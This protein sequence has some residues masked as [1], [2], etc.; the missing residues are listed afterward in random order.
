MSNGSSQWRAV[1]GGGSVKTPKERLSLIAEVFLIHEH[2][3]EPSDLPGTAGLMVNRHVWPGRSIATPPP[4]TR[5]DPGEDEQPTGA[6]LPYAS[7]P[8]GEDGLGGELRGGRDDDRTAHQREWDFLA[9]H[10]RA[11]YETYR[12]R[13]VRPWPQAELSDWQKVEALAQYAMQW[14]MRTADVYAGFHPVD[15]LLHSSYCT[16]A[17][18]VLQALA[19]VAG[20]ETRYIAIS[21]HAQVE[22]RVGGR[23]I[24]ADNIWPDGGVTPTP[25]NYAQITEDP[26]AIVLL[27]EKQRELYRVRTARYRAPWHFAGQ[28]YWHF[29]WGG[30]F[31]DRPR[32]ADVD[33]YG[34]AMPYDP[35]TAAAL[36]PELKRHAFR[37]WQGDVPALCISEQRGWVR[38]RVALTAGRAF[39]KVFYV[40]Q[41]PDNPVRGGLVKFR[42]PAPLAGSSLRVTLDGAPLAGGAPGVRFEQPTWDV[43]LPAERL[44][45]GEHELIVEP[46]TGEPELLF[47]PDILE[48]HHAPSR[49]EA[50]AVADEAFDVEPILRPETLEALDEPL[51]W[52][53]TGVAAAEPVAAR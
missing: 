23:W 42:L 40:G 49:G 19:M 7:Q 51:G 25:F 5:D 45:P 8:R 22:I 28:R 31:G 12:G 20:F 1:T 10:V 36:Y 53:P 33:G 43:A 11:A 27:T 34:L 15:V 13:L 48:P 24:W 26:D 47:G 32:Y 17:A 37:V 38:G 21:N 18:N 6:Y 39:R 29:C 16:G 35:S 52:T 3:D 9:G 41:T 50:I 14:K 4:V 2:L 46:E 30:K 44:T